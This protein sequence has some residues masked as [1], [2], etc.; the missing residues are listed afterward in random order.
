MCL[1]SIY[2]PV[3]QE[4]Y[5]LEVLEKNGYVEKSCKHLVVKLLI[6][7]FMLAMGYALIGMLYPLTGGLVL[8]LSAYFFANTLKK[9]YSRFFE[10]KAQPSNLEIKGCII[11]IVNG[12]TKVLGGRDKIDNLPVMKTGCTQ[13]AIMRTLGADSKTISVIFF[14]LI[15]N[16]KKPS[17]CNIKKHVWMYT[18][19]P[20]KYIQQTRRI[21]KRHHA[22]LLRNKMTTAE[23]IFLKHLVKNQGHLSPNSRGISYHMDK[24]MD[25]NLL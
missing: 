24:E 17:T 3:A 2:S 5:D 20:C 23:M 18:L 25:W 15:A 7:G 14:F 16:N 9:A 6:E 4:S 8:G 1:S 12:L 19:K 21:S 13:K 11:D 10:D 22:I